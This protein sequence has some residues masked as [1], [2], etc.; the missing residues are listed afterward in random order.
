MP[1]SFQIGD[2]CLSCSS[3]CLLEWWDV[4]LHHS[5]L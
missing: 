2:F 4:S 3:A 1:E 5:T